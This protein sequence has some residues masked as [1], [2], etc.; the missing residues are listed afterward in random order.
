MEGVCH[1]YDL[2]NIPTPH[3]KMRLWLKVWENDEVDLYTYRPSFTVDTYAIKD[4][5]EMEFTE[6]EGED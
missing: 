5:G 1:P 6:G 4:L 2:I 3:K